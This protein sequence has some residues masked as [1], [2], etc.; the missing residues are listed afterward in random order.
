MPQTSVYLAKFSSGPS[1]RSHFGIFFPNPDYD[2][3]DL[4]NDFRS[5]ATVGIQIHVV[6]EPLMAGYMLEM[7]RH[8]DIQNDRELKALVP[9]GS[10][11]S[12]NLH[13]DESLDTMI[14]DYVP[15]SIVERLAD[16]VPPPPR[17]QDVRAPIDGVNT[18]RCQEW[19]MEFLKLLTQKGLIS[20]EAVGIA[21]GERFTDSRD[22]WI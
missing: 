21:Q 16:S 10:I 18:K 15:K 5:Q 19:T 4:P 13:R 17:G 22:L 9:L 6:G 2:R 1:K 14:R 3:V 20:P 11:D 12:S 7:K 8:F